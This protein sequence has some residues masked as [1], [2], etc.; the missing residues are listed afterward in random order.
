MMP[1]RG[2][3]SRRVVPRSTISLVS[4][5]ALVLTYARHAASVAAHGALLV[6]IALVKRPRNQ[7]AVSF[8]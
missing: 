2:F 5:R 1:V 8:V 4:N 6:T 7:L 3:Q